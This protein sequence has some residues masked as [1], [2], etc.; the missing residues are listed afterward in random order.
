M[1]AVALGAS[2]SWNISTIGAVPE[3]VANHFGIG[4]A[5]VGL[6][7]TSLFL[8]QTL[9]MLP[10]GRL[11][12]RIGPRETGLAALIILACGNALSLFAGS[13]PVALGLR[14]AVGFA[15]GIGLLAGPAYV[16]GLGGRALHHGLYGG[17]VF[18]IGGLAVAVSSLLEPVLGW[19][20]PFATAMAI[21]LLAMPILLQGPNS[22]PTLQPEH[23]P[24][25]SLLLDRRMLRFAVAFVSSFGLAV[26]L[27]NWT[28]TLL[29]R[30]D[31]IDPGSAGA[32]AALILGMS[33]V[34]RPLGGILN[35]RW[36]GGAR[37]FLI[38]AAITGSTA[39]L[40]LASARPVAV[41]VVAAAT[42]GMMAG[43]PYG[44][45]LAGL[46]HAFPRQ[47][48]S[49]IGA[50][51]TYAVAAIVVCTPL[52]GVTFSLPGEGLIGFGAAGLLWF[53]SVAG[54]PRGDMLE[55]PA[56]PPS[57]PLPATAQASR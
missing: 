2:A 31:G 54:L 21:A 48:G 38:A 40:V 9:L 18:S 30:R 25:L 17:A 10:A 32:I 22:R 15:V 7:T 26:I 33:I 6:F 44:I 57:Q 50:M 42:V 46:G 52:L 19:R 5:A 4:L 35:H 51:S 39:T 27:S 23:V 34:G 56:S 49:A 45:L 24:A 36:P 28:V 29:V 43:L 47:V 3:A 53:A 41:A 55:G 13:L 14:F 11:I 12:D 1:A 8:A 37:T 16:K 20:S